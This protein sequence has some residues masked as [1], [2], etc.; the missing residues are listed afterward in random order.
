M[1]YV[2]GYCKQNFCYLLQWRYCLPELMSV[3]EDAYCFREY[4]ELDRL[5]CTTASDFLDETHLNQVNRLAHNTITFV[6]KST[7]ITYAMEKPEG[8]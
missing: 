2:G 7:S 6:S 8:N 4:V 3:S 5:P 1:Q